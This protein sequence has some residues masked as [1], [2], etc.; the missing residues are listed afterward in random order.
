[1]TTDRLATVERPS[2]AHVVPAGGTAALCGVA[3]SV[4]WQFPPAGAGPCLACLYA[5]GRPSAAAGS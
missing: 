4:G 3:T 5:A 1:M 2:L